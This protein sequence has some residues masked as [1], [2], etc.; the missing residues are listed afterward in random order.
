VTAEAVSSSA[1]DGGGGGR[2]QRP[3]FAIREAHAHL[4][5]LGEALLMP[6]LAECPT[7]GACLEA[8]RAE[9]ARQRAA[10]LPVF[11]RMK[12]VRVEGWTEH[13]WPTMAEMDAAVPDGPCVLMSFDHHAAAANTAAF[14]RAGLAPGQV[15]PPSGVVVTDAAGQATGLLLEHAA[16]AAWNAAPEPTAGERTERLEAALEHLAGLGFAE[17]HDLLSQDWLGPALGELERKGRLR[18]QRV[19]LYAPV[20]RLT[21]LWAG[22]RQWESER[23]SLAGGKVFA[24]GTLNSRTALMIHRYC[25][26][27][28]AAPRGRAMVSPASLD[29]SVRLADGLGMDLA[30]HAIGDGAVRMVLDSVERVRPSR[31]RVRIEH[32]EVVD[33]ADVGRFVALGV[34]CSVQPCHLLTDIEAL[35]RYVP[36]RLDRVLPLKELLASGLRPGWLACDEGPVAA[37][38]GGGGG[39]RKRE[40]G[41]VFGSDVPIVPAEPGDSLTAAVLRRRTGMAAEGA[42]APEQAITPEQAWACFAM[43]GAMTGAGSGRRAGA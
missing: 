34:D 39:G 41:L 14:A 28:P 43:P 30:V 9:A 32:A 23:V 11:V 16:Y 31:C 17:V 7:V 6:N 8:C 3:A 12:S 36:H 19:R 18:L 29:E 38:G 1:S 4:A 27:L 42:I 33:K 24:D 10:G 40:A 15:V 13:R 20:A 35:T 26:A 22:R 25:D 21:D 2:A 5:S 37:G